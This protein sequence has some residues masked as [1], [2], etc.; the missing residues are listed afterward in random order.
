MGLLGWYLFFSQRTCSSGMGWRRP[1]VRPSVKPGPP[2]KSSLLREAGESIRV[3]ARTCV[4]MG[5]EQSVY[6][7][8]N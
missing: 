6:T 2:Q 3:R 8:V 7:W 4:A 1:C 5:I